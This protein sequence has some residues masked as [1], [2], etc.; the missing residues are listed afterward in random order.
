MFL[1][2]SHALREETMPSTF[3]EK[4][5][6]GA[7]RPACVFPRPEF[8]WCYECWMCY[9]AVWAFKSCITHYFQVAASK[10]NMRHAKRYHLNMRW[11]FIDQS[12]LVR[13]VYWRTSEWH[14]AMY[15]TCIYQQLRACHISSRI[16]V[17]WRPTQFGIFWINHNRSFQWRCW[18]VSIR[19]PNLHIKYAEI[20]QPYF[21]EKVGNLQNYK[22]SFSFLR[23]EPSVLNYWLKRISTFYG[24]AMP[25]TV[26]ER[27]K[28]CTV[29][30]R[31][32]AGIVGSNPT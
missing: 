26:A 20:V 30:A 21:K 24:N 14:L 27:S 5:R 7:R 10:L 13:T 32:E 15:C 2:W 28:A 29:F 23:P 12:V 16:F 31:S 3:L 19:F 17:R 25:V 9:I 18:R 4:P 22:C 6:R 11:R 8:T 1:E